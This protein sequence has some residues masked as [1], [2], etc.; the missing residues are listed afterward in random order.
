MSV[1]AGISLEIPLKWQPGE[2]AQTRDRLC[3][4]EIPGSP[5]KSAS[6]QPDFSQTSVLSRFLRI[7]ILRSSAKP[8]STKVFDLS[9]APILGTNNR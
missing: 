7:S 2:S 8:L 6:V 5:R 3:H 4:L 9:G 1:L